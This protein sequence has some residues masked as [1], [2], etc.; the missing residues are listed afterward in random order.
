MH[1]P[2]SSLHACHQV[3]PYAWLPGDSEAGLAALA[4]SL[5]TLSGRS[6]AAPPTSRVSGAHTLPPG[7]LA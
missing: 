1:S 4:A 5:A 7:V 6:A 2:V 3:I